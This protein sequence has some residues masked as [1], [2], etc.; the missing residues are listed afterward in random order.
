MKALFRPRILAALF[1]FRDIIIVYSHHV[2]DGYT[3]WEKYHR[4]PKTRRKKGEHQFS[5]TGFQVGIGRPPS[6]IS[7]RI[8]WYRTGNIPSVFQSFPRLWIWPLAHSPGQQ[9]SCPKMCLGI[10]DDLVQN[11][12]SHMKHCS[13][14]LFLMHWDLAGSPWKGKFTKPFLHYG[15]QSCVC[16]K[17]R[18]REG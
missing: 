15:S 4:T 18:I 11:W 10:P 1:R 17:V 16:E 12:S 6:C 5:A 8:H 7:H 2:T 3:K 9:K 13:G 14:N